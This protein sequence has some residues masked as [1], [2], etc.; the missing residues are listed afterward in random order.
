MSLKAE[1]QEIDGVGEVT[2]EKVITIVEEHQPDSQA[3]ELV[4]KALEE[5]DEGRPGYARKYLERVGE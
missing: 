2:A 4:K 5:L 3:T 1:L